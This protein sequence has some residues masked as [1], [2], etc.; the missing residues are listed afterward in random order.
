[1]KKGYDIFK[2]VNRAF[3][4]KWPLPS[5]DEKEMQEESCGKKTSIG[6]G[7]NAVKSLLKEGTG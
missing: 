2:L 3:S 1:M 5:Q 4:K 7:R 6:K